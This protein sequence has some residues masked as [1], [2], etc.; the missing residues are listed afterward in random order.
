MLNLPKVKRKHKS[1]TQEFYKKK[2]YMTN[3]EV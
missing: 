2:R 1:I 3:P